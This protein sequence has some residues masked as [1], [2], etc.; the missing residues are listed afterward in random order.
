MRPEVHLF[1][2]LLLSV[3]LVLRERAVILKCVHRGGRGEVA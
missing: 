1:L 2:F 3:L